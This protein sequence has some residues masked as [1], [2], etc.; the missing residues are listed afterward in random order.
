MVNSKE[1]Y[2][3][4]LKAEVEKNNQL[5]KKSSSSRDGRKRSRKSLANSGNIV[6]LQVIDKN[7]TE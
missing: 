4:N 2:L 5:S 6:R 1:A 7:G 3:R